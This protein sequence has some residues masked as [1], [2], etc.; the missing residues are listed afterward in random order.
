MVQVFITGDTTGDVTEGTG[1]DATGQLDS[2]VL[3]F[4]IESTWTI[5]DFPDFG[6]ATLADI[7]DPDTGL[8]TVTGES[9]LWRYELDD[10]NPA[11]EDLVLGE[12]LTDSF[13]IQASTPDNGIATQ[14]IDIT[15]FGVCFAAGTMI[16]TDKGPVRVED[17]ETGQTV[18]TRDGGPQPIQWLGG[19]V[20][21]EAD[22][23]ADKRL[24]P[25]R[26]KAGA[27]GKGLPSRDLLVS[28][29]HRLLFEDACTELYFGE[30]DVLVAAKH[31]C[32][33]PGVDIVIPEKPLAY[34]HI[35]CGA[36]DILTANGCA[37]ESMLLGE[38][39]LISIAPDDLARLDTLLVERLEP[40]A[41]KRMSSACR[42]IL[43][44]REAALLFG[45]NGVALQEKECRQVA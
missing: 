7:V 16:E 2:F 20:C 34:Y 3:V 5:I 38:E 28:Q 41:V 19:G 45:G 30:S 6:T 26:I 31:L 43:T 40:A 9:V 1:V 13:V 44:G 39:A 22:W 29:N 17:L 15:I 11:V 24:L 32:V 33:L 35:L 36:H 23:R 42:H 10:S 4:P 27:L 25:V 14:T 18:L 8:V 12:T 37:A 21:S